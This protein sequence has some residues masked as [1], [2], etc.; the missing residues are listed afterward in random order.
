MVKK[1]L[2]K[3]RPSAV[4]NFKISYFVTWLSSSFKRVIVYQMSSKSDDFS[5]R[6]SYL[7]ILRMAAVQRIEFL[8]L[9]FMARE[10]CGHAIGR[11]ILLPHAK[12][13]WNRSIGCSVMRCQMQEQPLLSTHLSLWCPPR[14]SSWPSSLC[15]VYNPAQYSNLIYVLK[16]PLVCW[17]HT[18]L[19]F[20]PSIRI[21]L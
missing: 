11:T 15:H 3:L 2:L 18:T 8:N 6:N 17:R 19:P 9:E 14:L 12:C 16:S 1:R 20:F 4:L 5:S 10:L 7:T 13:H 21:P